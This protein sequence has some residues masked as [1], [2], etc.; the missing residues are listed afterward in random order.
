MF[1]IGDQ[2][3]VHGIKRPVTIIKILR[4]GHGD[5][6]YEWDSGSSSGFANADQLK[7]V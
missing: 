2:V 7:K 3:K 6:L 4:N 1:H 5:L